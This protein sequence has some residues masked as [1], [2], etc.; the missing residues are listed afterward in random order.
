MLKNTGLVTLLSHYWE[1]FQLAWKGRHFD[2]RQLAEQYESEFLPDAIELQETNA[3]PIL[4]WT[5]YLL[6][7]MIAIAI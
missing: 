6:I 7:A 3:S 2:H 5:A 1:V 4:A